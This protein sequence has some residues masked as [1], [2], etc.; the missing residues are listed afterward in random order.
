MRRLAFLLPWLFF[1]SVAL[2]QSVPLPGFPPGVFQN[3]AALDAGGG[4]AYVGPGNVV[5][6]AV[7][8]WGLRCYNAAYSGNV[9]DITDSS[10]GNTTG[11]RLQ[12]SAGTVSALVSGSA[13]TFVTGNACSTLAVTCAVACNVEKLYD[14]SGANSCSAACDVTQATNASRPTYSSTCTGL[15]SKPCMTF[16]AAQGL[17]SPLYAATVAQPGTLSQVYKQISGP[18]ALLSTFLCG[19][20]GTNFGADLSNYC[21]LTQSHISAADNAWHTAQGVFND[22]ASASLLYVDGGSGASSPLGV[23]TFLTSGE[24]L[25]FGFGPGAD[26]NGFAAEGGIW[27]IAFNTTQADNMS[28]NQRAYWGF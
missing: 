15:T 6:G 21:G 17:T 10:T 22:G 1:A 19:L 26:F 23:T 11:T 5:S 20:L 9:A 18:S 25:A 14:Q 16:S 8:W 28:S 24:P 13:C 3:R 4:A 27:I 2:A 12:C 7:A